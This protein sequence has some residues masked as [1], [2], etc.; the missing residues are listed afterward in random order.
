MKVAP[1]AVGVS[2]SLALNTPN[3]ENVQEIMGPCLNTLIKR[4]EQTDPH[5]P[6]RCS[7]RVLTYYRRRLQDI[8]MQLLFKDESE[9]QRAQM[10][11][12]DYTERYAALASAESSRRCSTELARD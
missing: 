7:P 3:I 11:V 1:T 6:C 2:R 10:K 9:K 8:A 5:F 12:T 4:L